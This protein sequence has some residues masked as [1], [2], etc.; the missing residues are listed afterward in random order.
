VPREK[1]FAVKLLIC[2]S[3]GGRRAELVQEGSTKR[4]RGSIAPLLALY[5]VSFLLILDIDR[6]R[7]GSQRPMEALAPQPYADFAKEIPAELPPPGLV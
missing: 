3:H 4:F 1:A 5:A 6:S 7:A 2:T